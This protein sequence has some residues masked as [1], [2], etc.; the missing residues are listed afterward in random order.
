MNILERILQEIEKRK[1]DLLDTSNEESELV[2]VEDW[3]DEGFS[4]GRITG[5]CE[6]EKLIQTHVDEL[7][8]PDNWHR[9]E[10]TS[11]DDTIFMLR[12][13]QNPPVDYADVVYAPAFCCGI[14]DVYPEPEDYAIKTAI[15]VLKD[16]KEYDWISVDEHLPEEHDSIFAKFKGTDMW[17][18]GMF[19]KRSDEVNVTIEID[20]KTRKTITSYTIDGKWKCEKGNLIGKQKVVA[21]KPFPEP[22]KER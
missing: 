11:I 15:K 12:A 21:W 4:E 19:E 2:D 14:K 1:N 22:Y 6:I 3:Y 20:N 16:K 17:Y 9:I 7:Y 5:Y 10:G 13:M 8:N 18:E